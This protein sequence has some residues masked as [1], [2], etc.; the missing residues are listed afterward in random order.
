M[1]KNELSNYYHSTADGRKLT[2]DK[3]TNDV[4]SAQLDNSEVQQLIDALL[5]KQSELQQWRKVS[6][7]PYNPVAASMN[8][9]LCRPIQLPPPFFISLLIASS[10]AY[11][12]PFISFH[13]I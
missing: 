13:L 8:Y 11:S 7:Y 1:Y 12:F 10:F 4:A 9:F 3:L 5:H 6:D 2:V